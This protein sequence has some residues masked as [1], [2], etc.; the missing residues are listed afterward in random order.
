[1]IPIGSHF[2][3]PPKAKTYRKMLCQLITMN[4]RVEQGTTQRVIENA[5]YMTGYM[6]RRARMRALFIESSSVLRVFIFA[7]LR[8]S[9]SAVL[10][11]MSLY[12]LHSITEFSGW[13]KYLTWNS[14]VSRLRVSPLC[15]KEFAYDTILTMITQ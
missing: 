9:W 7:A 14:N 5:C 3:F 11:G 1:M 6:I 10:L 2:S 13:S 4:K 15:I 12:F 8:Q